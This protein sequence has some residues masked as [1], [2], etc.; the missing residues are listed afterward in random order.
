MILL[1]K[2]KIIAA[3]HAMYW[4]LYEQVAVR[5]VNTSSDR[6]FVISAQFCVTSTSLLWIGD[7][8]IFQKGFSFERHYPIKFTLDLVNRE[9]E[10]KS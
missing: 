9:N 7:M 8:Y 4:Q 3:N 2:A 10:K 1:E 6:D 5:V